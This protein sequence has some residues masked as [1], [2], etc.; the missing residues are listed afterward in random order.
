MQTQI[1]DIQDWVKNEVEEAVKFAEESPYPEAHELYEDVY[2][3]EGY[4][5]IVE[6]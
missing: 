5:F 4:P 2:K 3:T 1:Q 6:Y